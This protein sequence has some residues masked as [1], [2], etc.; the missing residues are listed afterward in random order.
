MA[1]PDYFEDTQPFL[2]APIGAVGIELWTMSADILFDNFL[3]TTEKWVADRLAGD[4]WA[5]KQAK[6]NVKPASSVSVCR[7]RVAP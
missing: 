1:N 7:S 4:T 6:E 3:I 2:M 5:L